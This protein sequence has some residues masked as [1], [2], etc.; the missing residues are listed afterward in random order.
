MTDAHETWQAT[1]V[2]RPSDI[3]TAT[4][5][6][7]LAEKH[8]AHSERLM[9]RSLPADFK[10]P[11]ERGGHE[12]ALAQLA[13]GVEIERTVVSYQGSTLHQALQLGA[14]WTEAA[15]ALDITPDTARDLL[16]AWADGQHRLY[17]GLVAEGSRPFGLDDDEHAA[18]IGMLHLRNDD[19]ATTTEQ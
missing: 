11:V 13:L 6:S 3:P 17:T 7:W 9:N 18:A 5:L 16:R 14:T 15:A 2:R 4:P 10:Y 12:D 1:E 8:Y 19:R